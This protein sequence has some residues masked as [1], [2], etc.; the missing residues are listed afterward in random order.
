MQSY[1][2]TP[3]GPSSPSS[4]FNMSSM[5]SPAPTEVMDITN[6]LNKKGGAAA[7]VQQ[8]LPGVIH[9]HHHQIPLVK[10][11]PGME[12]SASPHGSEHSHYS[13]HHSMNRG[14][15]S[16]STM[17]APMHIPNPMP[18]AMQLPGFPDMGNMGNMAHMTMQQMPQQPQVQQQPVK[19]FPCSTCGKGFARRSDLARHGKLFALA[20]AGNTGC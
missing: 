14:Y 15:P 5:R 12:R 20:K 8:H 2:P 13:N 6:M 9:D 10:P 18:A 1:Y 4:P 19:A 3:P 7:Q 16:P 17:Q 11:E